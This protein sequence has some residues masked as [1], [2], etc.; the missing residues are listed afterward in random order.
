M[1]PVAVGIFTSF[2]TTLVTKGAEAPART[3]DLLWQITLGRWDPK[4]Q[5]MVQENIEK[6]SKDIDEEVAKI[7]ADQINPEPDI[8][9][10]GPALEASKYYVARDDAREMFAKLIAAEL[11]LTKKG[12]VHH[13]FVDIIKQ[14]SS[15]DAKLLCKLPYVGPL[16]EVR[17]YT[18]DGKKY[19]LLGY[20]DV[21]DI[22]GVIDSDFRDNAVSINNLARLG[23][24][25][26]DHVRSL[27]DP[28]AYE[29]YKKLPEYL[30]GLI[31]KA[32]HSDQYSDVRVEPG[33]FMMTPFG[34]LF[35]EICLGGKI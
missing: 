4:M 11:N 32:S 16:G 31:I 22:P 15:N 14:M 8:S 1:D 26:I 7:P 21:I 13:A 33:M 24:V 28:S 27:N 20:G 35:R 34:R 10:I 30:K 3:L 2:A 18:K 9:L 25:E 5:A 19:Q 6:Y 12:K 23:L 29:P 17:L